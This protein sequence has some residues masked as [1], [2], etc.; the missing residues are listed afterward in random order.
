M[1]LNVEDLAE[2][3]GA[4]PLAACPSRPA[5]CHHRGRHVPG[6]LKVAL[7]TVP[8]SYFKCNFRDQR[9]VTLYTYREAKLRGPVS[10]I[11]AVSQ[12]GTGGYTPTLDSVRQAL[13]Y[14]INS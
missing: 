9:S 5:Q 7:P 11:R 4:G 12:A 2:W 10:G 14:T 1:W 3:E 8:H 13:L 6:A